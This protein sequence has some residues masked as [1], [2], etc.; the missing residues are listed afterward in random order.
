MMIF[1]PDFYLL[2]HLSSAA[3]SRLKESQGHNH[4]VP[5]FWHHYRLSSGRDAKGTIKYQHCLLTLD[6]WQWAS[7]KVVENKCALAFY[8]AFLQ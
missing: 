3:L 8:K 4:A 5:S 1:W 7:K 6:N 2:T